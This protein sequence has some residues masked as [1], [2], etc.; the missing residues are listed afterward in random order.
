[1]DIIVLCKIISTVTEKSEQC[2]K[3]ANWVQ[4]ED[5]RGLAHLLLSTVL[6]HSIFPI[7][8]TQQVFEKHDIYPYGQHAALPTT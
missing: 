4:S 8:F 7:H 2:L 3:L 5:I 6:T 1:M